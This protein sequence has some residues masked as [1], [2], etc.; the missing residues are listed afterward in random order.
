MTSWSGDQID[1][2]TREKN[3]DEGGWLPS[4]DKTGQSDFWI[5]LLPSKKRI[6]IMAEEMDVQDVTEVAEVGDLSVV[7][8]LKEVLRK[9]LIHDGLRRGLHE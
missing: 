1:C 8:A 7:D 3:Y 4:I 6:I 2:D 9:A 5:V